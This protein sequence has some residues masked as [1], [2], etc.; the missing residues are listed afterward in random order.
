[1]Q[2]IGHI[3]VRIAKGI[4]LLRFVIPD[5]IAPEPKIR[6]LNQSV[7]NISMD[8]VRVCQRSVEGLYRKL[9]HTL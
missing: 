9:L 5:F 8:Q 2:L 1:M 4:K 6:Y 3:G 7:D